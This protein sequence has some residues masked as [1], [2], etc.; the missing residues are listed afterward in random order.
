MTIEEL[1]EALKSDREFSA[2]VSDDVLIVGFTDSDSTLAVTPFDGSVQIRQI[3]V[4]ND[5]GYL[6][7]VMTAIDRTLSKINDRFSCCKVFFDDEANVVNACDV[8]SSV[9]SLDFVKDM[10]AQTEFV[11]QA[12][13]ATL[14]EVIETGQPASDEAI[15]RAFKLPRVH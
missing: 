13:A 7:G 9:A 2:E 6:P 8:P 11:S 14:A 10:L 15:D 12:C 5:R 1:A 3:I 4:E